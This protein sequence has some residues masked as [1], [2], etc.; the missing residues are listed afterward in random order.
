MGLVVVVGG[1]SGGGGW[2]WWWWWMGLVVV[3]RFGGGGWV[4][5]WTGLVVEDG[6]HCMFVNSKTKMDKYTK[7]Q[8]LSTQYHCAG[9]Y[10]CTLIF[11][12]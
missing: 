8:L 1:F 3:D 6:F 10:I 4:R 5:W 7:Q 12:Y 11:S 2:V 9:N